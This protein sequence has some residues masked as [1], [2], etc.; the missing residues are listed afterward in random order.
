MSDDKSIAEVTV[1]PKILII[2]RCVRRAVENYREGLCFLQHNVQP[3]PAHRL[4][5]TDLQ[6]VRAVEWRIA[7]PNG[8]R[9]EATR[10]D[11][12]VAAIILTLSMSEED[13]E[14]VLSPGVRP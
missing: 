5:A 9:P 12:L 7:H 6:L 11:V 13:L 4:D 3:L 8:F 14:G 2:A 1:D 10:E